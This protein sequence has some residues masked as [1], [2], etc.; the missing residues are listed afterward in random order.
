MKRSVNF[1]DACVIALNFPYYK[2][3]EMIT[4]A[5]IISV[6]SITT[7]YI[8]QHVIDRSNDKTNPQHSDPNVHLSDVLLHA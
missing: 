5:E 2:S 1:R 3:P 7:V 4:C 8:N 6:E